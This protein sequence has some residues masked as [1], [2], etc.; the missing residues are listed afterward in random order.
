MISVGDY[1]VLKDVNNPEE[2]RKPPVFNSHMKRSVK[3]KEIFIVT[4][5]GKE[6]RNV[7]RIENKDTYYFSKISW[8]EKPTES[9]IIAARL[10]GEI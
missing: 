4:D 7:V 2:M 1:V 9:E 5:T 10:R 3:K 8:L 6:G